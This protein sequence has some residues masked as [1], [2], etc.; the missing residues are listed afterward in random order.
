MWRV[1]H[2]QCPDPNG[3]VIFKIERVGKVNKGIKEA[4]R[5][6]ATAEMEVAESL[7]HAP[8]ELRD[9]RVVVEDVRGKCTSGMRPEDFFVLRSGRLTV[10]ADR[11]FCLYAL[12][13]VLP[14]LAAKQRHLQEGDWLKDEHHFVCP[15]PA[16][17]VIMRV[18]R[19]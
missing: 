7:G 17:S 4:E 6:V 14:F 11:H 16:G 3:R 10:P 13:A 18:E 15:D 12:Q 8:G 1:H 2:A 19:C 9:L 5:P